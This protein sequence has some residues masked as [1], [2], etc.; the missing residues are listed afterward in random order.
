MGRRLGEFTA[1][2]TKCMLEVNG[3]PLIDRMLMQ[4]RKYDLKQIVVV[5]GY[6]GEKL[7]KY[8]EAGYPDLPLVFVD[9]P[10]Y[11]KTNNIYSLWLARDEMAKDETLLLESDLIFKH[12]VLRTIVDSPL[13]DCALVS[14]YQTWMDGT[15][16]RMDEDNSILS[17]IPKKAFKYSDTEHY[18]KTVNIYKFSRE[19]IVH[20]Y[21]PF[22][23]AYIRVLGENEY[24]EQVLRVL[25]MIDKTVITAIPIP[26]TDWYEIDDVQDLRIA[27]ILF[28]DPVQKLEKIQKSY[29]GYW[30]YPGMLDFCYLVNPYFPRRKMIE[31]MKANFEPL[32]RDYP[33]GMGVN[34]LLAAKYFDLS[35]DLVVVGNGAA[36]LIK[37][38][39]S[40]LP[41]TFGISYPTFEEYPNRLSPDRVVKFHP[42]DADFHY[43]VDELMAFYGARSVDNILLINPDNPS[44]NFIAR[45]DI[46]RL[47]EWCEQQG[48]RLIVDESFVDFADDGLAQTLLQTSL[49]QEHP[50]LIVV[51]SISKSY[52]VPGL[53]LG[54]MASGDTRTIDLLRKDV[55][56]WNI[57]SFAEF[58]MQ[59]YGKYEKDYEEACERFR[60]ERELFEKELSAIDWLRVIPSQANYF[61][62]E[63]LDAEIAEKLALRLLTEFDILIKDCS[64]KQG[65]PADRRYIRLAIRDRAD[66][67]RLVSA[68]LTIR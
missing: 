64:T 25:A 49:L 62:C 54:V 1:H 37:S 28:A 52:G 48:K 66:D 7:R 19:F 38:L 6:E 4:L 39:P 8:L 34:S 23:D 45:T 46:L 9:N 65:F 40:I 61:L 27:E 29:G 58:Y 18:Y 31:E 15:M 12:D 24:Y 20:H 35:H 50:S 43:T 56:I 30:R 3:I 10:V 2:N 47:L 11:D 33:S 21:L 17:F 44:G 36:E 53:R 55:G 59:I 32:L 57:N 22:L 63:V 14:H 68:M 5:T 67:H 16:I 13:K 41:G 60:K 42:S 51:K 26:G